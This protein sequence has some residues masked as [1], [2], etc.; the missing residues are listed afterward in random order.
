MSITITIGMTPFMTAA[1]ILAVMTRQCLA[2]MMVM[3]PTLQGLRLGMT[4]LATKLEW[5]RVQSGLRAATRRKASARQPDTSSAWNFSLPLIRSM[6]RRMTVIQ[7][8]R[9]I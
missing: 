6:V 3:V 8:K 1:A 5:H 7:A 4:A 2:M 9:P